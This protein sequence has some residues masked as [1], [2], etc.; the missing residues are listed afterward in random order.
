[1]LVKLRWD[2][3]DLSIYYY[4]VL[5]QLTPLLDRINNMYT[6]LKRG[7]CESH[8]QYTV[9]CP[10][11]TTSRASAIPIIEALYNELV[12]TL[13]GVAEVCIPKVQVNALKFWCSQ[14]ASDLKSRS[15]DAHRAGVNAHKP[16][17]GF[18]FDEQ[19]EKKYRYKLFLIRRKKKNSTIK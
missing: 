16:K 7:I 14:E 1:M 8:Y 9:R 3:A 10:V 2:H 6:S 19:K 12:K 13:A 15:I 5:K 17:Q 11:C 18:L 4:S